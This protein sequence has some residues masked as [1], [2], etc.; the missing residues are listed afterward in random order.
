MLKDPSFWRAPNRQVFAV[1]KRK[2]EQFRGPRSPMMSPLPVPVQPLPAPSQQALAAQEAVTEDVTDVK[3]KLREVLEKV[4]EIAAGSSEVEQLKQ[5]LQCAICHQP[6][7]HSAVVATCCGGLI[8]CVRCATRYLDTTASF[9]C[10]LCRTQLDL[11]PREARWFFT[12]K[13]VLCFTMPQRIL[14]R[15]LS[16]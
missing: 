5:F 13:G 9:T 7:T 12:P 1:L 8:G 6:V 16:T 15:R 2:L 3:E 14:Q 11:Q 10:P 4:N